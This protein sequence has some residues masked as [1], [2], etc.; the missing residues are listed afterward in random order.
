VDAR[1]PL[2]IGRATREA[3]LRALLKSGFGPGLPRREAD[4]FI[5]LHALAGE[6][7]PMEPLAEKQLTERIA[8]WLAGAGARLGTDAVTL[9]RALVDDG[10][11]E[12]D[13]R[14]I[15]YRRSR[16]HE[17]RV[18]FV[19]DAAP[20]APGEGGSPPGLAGE[21]CTA[22]HAGAPRV[23]DDE[24]RALLEEL[25]EWTIE[26]IGG[27]PRLSR[28]YRVKDFAAAL[29]LA[30]RVGAEAEAADHHPELRVEWGRLTVGWWTHAIGG[31]HRNDFIMAARTD[32]LAG[33]PAEA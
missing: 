22:C 15:A 1:A 30:V 4:R 13:G 31:L 25:P 10:F 18:V 27:V 12:R 19:E 29:D 20:P 16:A 9:R 6:F 24:A 17:M 3:R 26:E 23:G 14:G 7:D 21:R 2:V 33:R 32:R 28:T 11:L 8:A 5:L